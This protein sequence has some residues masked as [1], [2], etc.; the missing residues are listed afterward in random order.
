MFKGGG[1]RG[2][3]AGGEVALIFLCIVLMNGSAQPGRLTLCHMVANNRHFQPASLLP[4]HDWVGEISTFKLHGQSKTISWL[5]SFIQ[6]NIYVDYHALSLNRLSGKPQVGC[7]CDPTTCSFKTA[8]LESRSWRVLL[9]CIQ[10]CWSF[11][12]IWRGRGTLRCRDC[13][14]PPARCF[15]K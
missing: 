13:S 9:I 14:R 10:L 4:M 7:D 11:P 3:G 5:L 6:Y 15:C 8:R 1:G 12:H 2:S